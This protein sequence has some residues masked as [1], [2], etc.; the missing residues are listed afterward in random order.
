MKADASKWVFEGQL[1][2]PAKASQ[3]IVTADVEVVVFPRRATAVPR[4][5]VWK[6]PVKLTSTAQQQTVS[7]EAIA[8]LSQKTSPRL[9]E[10]DLIPGEKRD[11]HALRLV[12]DDP[13][14]AKALA[15]GGT[16]LMRLT[17]DDP[18]IVAFGFRQSKVEP[19]LKV[20]PKNAE[21]DVEDEP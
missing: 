4:P 18:N 10:L 16:V 12:V 14:L 8:R 9:A 15:E 7:P 21:E 19:Y 3:E 2:L 1:S 11:R 5:L 17:V 6:A 20:D 13:L